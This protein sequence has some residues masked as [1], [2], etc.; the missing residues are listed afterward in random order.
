M[1]GF[2]NY[3]ES[4]NHIVASSPFSSI[5]AVSSSSS[6]SSSGPTAGKSRKNKPGSS[7]SS[8]AHSNSGKLFSSRLTIQEVYQLKTLILLQPD[9]EGGGE[10]EESYLEVLLE[11][12]RIY[13]D[14]LLAEKLKVWILCHRIVRRK[15]LVALK[16]LFH[17]YGG[18]WATNTTNLSANANKAS[19]NEVSSHFKKYLGLVSDVG[20]SLNL[21]FRSLVMDRL[22]DIDEGVR[23]EAIGAAALLIH[24]YKAESHEKVLTYMYIYAV[25]VCVCPMS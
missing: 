25:C 7:S 8:S 21:S 19:Y 6:S 12:H 9:A 17:Y 11:K 13:I 1:K 22:N 4:V 23:N 20:K 18:A 16:L 2:N 3:H 15:Q 5:G 14:P 24:H 10:K